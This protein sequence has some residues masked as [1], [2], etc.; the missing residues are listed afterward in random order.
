MF[1][2]LRLVIFA[3]IA[4]CPFC[5]S[6]IGPP[7]PESD[8]DHLMNSRAEN[9]SKRFDQIK[10]AIV[11]VFKGSPDDLSSF[12]TGFYDS[13]NGDIIT[14]SHVVGDRVWAATTSGVTVDLISPESLTVVES[15]GER[16]T[17]PRSAIE[18]NRGE[19]AA[20]LAHIATGRK[21]G[22]WLAIDKD[23]TVKPGMPVITVGFPGLAFGSRGSLSIYQ[24]MV[25]A[26][27]V[28]NNLPIARI[29]AD[30][31]VIPVNQFIRVQ[32]PAC[33]GLSGAPII[34]D[35]N[36]AIAILSR[37]GVWPEELD[38]LIDSWDKGQLGARPVA[39]P[40]PTLQSNTANL[41]WFV[42][43][44]AWSSHKF[45][46]PGYGDSVPLSYLTNK[47]EGINQTS[48]RSDR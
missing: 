20:D 32:M 24:G 4:L 36:K 28:S 12:G 26:T 23:A 5:I 17:F 46:S 13:P 48:S 41:P 7:L 6:Q 14:A 47:T 39:Q 1:M 44:L 19:W 27:K 40:Q 18:E 43:A 31:F 10:C 33:P 22:C 42:G 34:N 30:N 16:F 9:N 15:T 37:A 35:E 8:M 25:S 11:Q 38:Q 45:A 2:S 3:T 29:S 21:T